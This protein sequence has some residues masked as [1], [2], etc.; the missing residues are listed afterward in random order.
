MFPSYS[1]LREE[2]VARF[3]LGED[4]SKKIMKKDRCFILGLGPSLTKINPEALKDE[5]VI[6][7]NYILRTKFVPDIVCMVDNRRYDYDNWLKTQIKVITVKQIAERRQDTIGNLN[8][9]HDID[10]T[11]Y[12]NGLTRDVLTINELDDRL[13]TV[14]FAGSVVADLAIPFASYLGFKEIYV[15]GLDGALA[16]YPSTY[17]FGNDKNYAAAYPNHMY[18][19]HEKTAAL[20]LKRGVKT[21]NASPGGVVFA[22]EKISLAKVKASAVRT[23]FKQNVDGHYVVLGTGIV[24]LVKQNGAYRLVSE[25]G[26]KYIRHKNNI[27]LLDKDDGSAQFEKDSTWIIE[28][29]FAKEGWGSF[30][31]VNAKGKYIT[32]LDEFSGYK[33]RAMD[34]VFS[35]YFSSFRFYENR[36]RAAPRVANNMILKQISAMK[37]AVGGSLLADDSY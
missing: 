16:S 1:D 29:S 3:G 28:P 21:F 35:P 25:S 26:E 11:D 36:E 23:D 22:L 31:S 33:L 14:N 18:H 17:I 32:A 30:R 6:G 13:A 27:V 19:L 15:L 8:A 10:Y 7:T 4:I 12:G 37:Q 2:R 20:A 24:R 9:Y 34:N 5:F